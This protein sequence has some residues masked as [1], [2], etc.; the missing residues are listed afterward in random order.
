MLNLKNAYF[1]FLAIK[2]NLIKQLKKIYF[3]TKFYN[4][5][6]NSRAPD[7]LY[8]HPNTFL[9]SSL[10]NH[11]SFSFKL[12][13]IDKDL[14]LE[15][16]KNKSNNN[17]LHNFLWLNLIDRKIDNKNLKRIISIWIYKN[18]TYKK[19]VWD[20]SVLSKRV[21][22]WILNS[23]IILKD[24]DLF[25]KQNFFR[26]I[27]KQ[28][29][30]LKK[31]IK[32]EDNYLKKV[33]IITAI[34]LSGL[35]FKE[36]S[37]NYEHGLKELEKLII[38]FFD[39]EGY[40]INK[41]PIDLIEISKF[42]IIIKECIKDAQEYTPEY[43]DEIIDKNL[44]CVKSITTPTNQIPLFHGATEINID[45]FIKYIETLGYKMKKN[46]NL[47]GNLQSI[48][49]KKHCIYFDV[50]AP[51]KKNFST[52]YQSGPLSF[53]Y[54]LDNEKIITNCGFGSNISKKAM[55]L[56]RLTSAQSTLSINDNSVV[57]FER[58]KLINSAFGNSIKN[59]F[60]LT[61]YNFTDKAEE[62]QCSAKHNAYEKDFSCVV[63]REIKIDKI[64]NNFLGADEFFRSKSDKIIKFSIRFH[65][66][67]GL[68]AVKTI[69]GNSVVIQVKKNKSLLFECFDQDI[70]IEKSIFLGRNK[71]LNN[72]CIHISGNMTNNYKKINW[73]I[74]KNI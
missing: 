52:N 25:F 4:N 16:K 26:I 47:I 12:E 10:T 67:P 56:S 37:E 74:K 55:L 38:K 43:L 35:V 19:V 2:I 46:K 60:K 32:F 62:I 8:F 21:I 73:L 57:K 20:N 3:T 53:E 69:G 50:G 72:L 9:L 48:K 39:E 64:N 40:P 49:N 18:S 44:N 22:S 42:L 27:I 24:S 14:F 29:N 66:Y 71:I 36:Y 23:D 28:V 11:K 51:P 7:Q 31:N 15:N 59:S 30:H 33:E 13:N 5:S 54:Y 70:S 61:D 34:L 6:L 45:Q 65:L 41:N 1:Y 17:S 68:N 63:R 58:N